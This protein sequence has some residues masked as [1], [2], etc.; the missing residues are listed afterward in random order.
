M[1]TFMQEELDIP[2]LEISDETATIEGGDVVFTGNKP[3]RFKFVNIS[4]FFT[5]I[6]REFFVGISSRTNLAGAN[7]LASAFPDYPCTP[8]RVCSCFSIQYCLI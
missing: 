5:S 2:I 6:G 7:A 8:V 4:F 1:K 3:L